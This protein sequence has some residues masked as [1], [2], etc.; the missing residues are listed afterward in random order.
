MINANFTD[1]DIFVAYF[2]NLVILA[3]FDIFYVISRTS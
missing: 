3:N 2:D 1:W